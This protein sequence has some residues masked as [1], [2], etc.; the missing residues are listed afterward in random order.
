MHGVIFHLKLLSL[1][2]IPN[3]FFEGKVIF[4]RIGNKELLF[5][6]TKN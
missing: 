5:S 3:K 4:Q 6:Q 1:V 2:K